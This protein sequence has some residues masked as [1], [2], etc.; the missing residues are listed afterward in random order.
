[1]ISSG[2]SVT[3]FGL[4][5]GWEAGAGFMSL[6]GG[7][8][9]AMAGGM[10]GRSMASINRVNKQYREIVSRGAFAPLIAL[11]PNLERIDHQQAE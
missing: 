7:I 3:P 2:Q 1:M 6:S 4:M 10:G 11:S 5:P 9:K 8:V